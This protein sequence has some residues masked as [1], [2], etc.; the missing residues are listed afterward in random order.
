LIVVKVHLETGEPGTGTGTGSE[1]WRY[2]VVSIGDAIGGCW[3]LCYSVSEYLLYSRAY[4]V[5]TE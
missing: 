2:D 4:D 1:E 3:G 5:Y